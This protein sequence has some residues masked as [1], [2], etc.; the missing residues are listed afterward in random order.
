MA[1]RGID[2]DDVTHVF[3]FD[4]PTSI[5]NFVHRVGRTGRAG[6]KGKSVTLFHEGEDRKK[7]PEFRKVLKVGA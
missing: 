3:N 5:D 1:S 2:V 4:M 7:G 6:R